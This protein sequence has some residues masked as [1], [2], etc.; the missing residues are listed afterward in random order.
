MACSQNNHKVT[1]FFWI[2]LA[3][4]LNAC[5]SIPMN[6]A[7]N[8]PICSKGVPCSFQD[9]EDSE[10]NSLQPVPRARVTVEADD[11]NP[12]AFVGL[13]LSGGGSRAA[14]FSMAVMR[15]LDQLGLLSHVSVISSTSGGGLAGAWYALNAPNVNWNTAVGAMETDFLSLWLRKFLFPPNLI[16]TGFTHL[17]RSDLMAEVFDETLFAGKTFGDLKDWGP[18]RPRWL[19]NSAD[20]TERGYLFTFSEESFANIGSRLDTY[21]IARAVMASAAL[22]GVFNSMTLR[23]WSQYGKRYTHLYDGGTADNLGL[24]SMIR[25]AAQHQMENL[26]QGKKPGCFIFVVDGYAAG[27]Q[28]YMSHEPDLHRRIEIIDTNFISSFDRFLERQRFELLK[29]V[30]LN[31]VAR[32]SLVVPEVLI[33]DREYPPEFLSHVINVDFNK[34]AGYNRGEGL[35]ADDVKRQLLDSPPPEDGWFRCTIWYI[36]LD[37][38]QNLRPY[39]VN[40]RGVTEA[41][42]EQDRVE[43]G[44]TIPAYP[45]PPEQLINAARYRFRLWSVAKQIETNFR[46]TGPDKCSAKS[47]QGVL[48]DSASIL[49]NEDHEARVHA[50][51]WFTRHGL[52]TASACEKMPRQLKAKIPFS[53]EAPKSLEGRYFSYSDS[54]TCSVKH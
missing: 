20:Q 6:T 23:R 48:E 2:A 17:D 54:M 10:R 36:A 38:L 14:V 34:W 18:G 33:A 51:E 52:Q 46:L 3:L 53:L 24:R 15:E 41:Y 25:T 32:L 8:D 16:A 9:E 31:P 12:P 44:L 4:S 43:Q 37:E 21:P 27:A 1:K 28:G 22:P 7:F 13:T 30:G 35:R 39:F 40:E 50:C 11:W 45:P 47:L 26:S 42:W 29:L 19:A 5:G 49:V